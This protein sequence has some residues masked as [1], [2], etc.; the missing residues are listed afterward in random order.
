MENL[1]KKQKQNYRHRIYATILNNYKEE[2][3]CHQV[4]WA[5]T[6][7]EMPHYVLRFNFWP[8]RKFYMHLDK[9]SFQDGGDWL[10][11]YKIFSQLRWSEKFKKYKYEKIVGSAFLKNYSTEFLEVFFTFPSQ[12][13]LMDLYPENMSQGSLAKKS[14]LSLVK[15]DKKNKKN[16]EENLNEDY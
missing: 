4:G 6:N 13:L 9:S 5:Y 12:K 16:K 1:L 3:I 8:Q 15:T 7:E 10:P 11:S 14:H 2:K